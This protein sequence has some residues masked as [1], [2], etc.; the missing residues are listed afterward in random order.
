MNVKHRLTARN[1]VL[2]LLSAIAFTFLIMACSSQPV[3]MPQYYKSSTFE[4]VPETGFVE[5]ASE[6]VSSAKLDKADEY[7]PKDF[8]MAK[9]KLRESKDMFVLEE[10]RDSQMLAQ[11]S[12]ID[13]RVAAAEAQNVQLDN[14]IQA[15]HNQ[16]DQL[17]KEV[18]QTR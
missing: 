5:H 16:V 6:A 13:A 4:Y 7:A 18:D 12:A 3:Q 17:Q 15:L 8:A 1:M 10:R 2:S 11:Q 14:E 9:D